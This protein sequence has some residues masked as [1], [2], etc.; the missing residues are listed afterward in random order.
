MKRR[1]ANMVRKGVRKQVR[2]IERKEG[3]GIEETIGQVR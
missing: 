2:R 3:E 1:E